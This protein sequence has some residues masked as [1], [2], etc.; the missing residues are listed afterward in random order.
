MIDIHYQNKQN[1]LTHFDFQDCVESDG[2]GTRSI[3]SDNIEY[4]GTEY[5]KTQSSINRF[6]YLKQNNKT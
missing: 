6:A 5:T 1:E 3:W 2:A 4:N